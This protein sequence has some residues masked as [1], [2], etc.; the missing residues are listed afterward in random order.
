MKTF[1]AWVGA[2]VIA[3]V[4]G[5]FVLQTCTRIANVESQLGIT[6]DSGSS[7]LETYLQPEA[8]TDDFEL[9]EL[10]SAFRGLPASF[11]EEDPTELE[12]TIEDLGLED[13]FDEMVVFLSRNPLE[14]IVAASGQISNYKLTHFDNEISSIRIS[15]IIREFLRGNDAVG[16]N[17]ELH[18]IGVRPS[19]T[20]GDRS[21]GA[22]FDFT[23]EGA[24]MRGEYIVFRRG[25]LVGAVYVYFLSDSQ[26]IVSIDEAARMLDLKMN[27]T[28]LA[29]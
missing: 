3:L 23:T 19:L 29:R 20:A 7:Q 22:F 15:D 8:Y 18:E 17:I 26:A 11:E 9:S 4:V 25:N 27:E 28:I 12:I 6:Y 5:V 16:A 2:L 14:M 10:R 13:Y 1:L 21:F 24:L